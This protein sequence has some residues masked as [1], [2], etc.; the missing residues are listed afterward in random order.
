MSATFRAVGIHIADFTNRRM[1]PDGRKGEYSRLPHCGYSPTLHRFRRASAQAELPTTKV[2]SC[3]SPSLHKTAVRP[4]LARSL[5]W[6]T[7]TLG[8]PPAGHPT[9]PGTVLCNMLE[10][11]QSSRSPLGVTNTGFLSSAPSEI[12]GIAQE[13]ACANARAGQ[14]LTHADRRASQSAARSTPTRPRCSGWRRVRTSKLAPAEGKRSA[15]A[16]R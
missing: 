4:E 10:G 16:A 9:L 1:A 5:H 6:G 8:A 14:H 7:G 15:I 2:F 3:N 12:E 11:Y 13:V